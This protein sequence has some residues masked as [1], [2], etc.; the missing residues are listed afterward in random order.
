MFWWGCE[1]IRKFPK[2][3]E[4]YARNYEFL[5]IYEILEIHE[6]YELKKSKFR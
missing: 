4:I 5:E 2:I 3:G 1:I 6:I